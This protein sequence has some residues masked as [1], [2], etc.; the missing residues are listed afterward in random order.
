MAT[1]LVLGTCDT[2]LDETLF[3]K[4]RIL[5]QAS[6]RK[7]GNNG[8]S[9]VLVMDV[10]R[11]AT[12]DDRIEIKQQEVVSR[13]TA[14]ISNGNGNDDDIT[15]LPRAE[16][17]RR[18]TTGAIV[19]AREEF[20]ASRIHGIVGLGGTCGTT[21]AT[22]VM[23]EALP[24]GFPKLMV[25]T[26]GSADVKPYVGETDITMMYSV[27][28]IAGINSIL[29]MALSNAA[30]AVAGMAL[31]YY[32]RQASSSED[33]SVVPSPKTKRV[34]ITM[35][36]VTTPCVDRIRHYLTSN[37][38]FEVYAFHATGS[39]GR[40][41]ERLIAERQLDAVLDLTTTEVADH[42]VGGVMDPGPHRLEMGAKSG[43]PQIVSVGACDMV[44]FGPP[45]TLPE[46]FRN[47]VGNTRLFHEHN[48]SITLMR[49]TPDES[50]AMGRFM[51]QRLRGAARPENV[52]VLLPVGGVSMLD[53]R[54][55]VFCDPMADAALFETLEDGLRG[56]GVKVIRDSRDINDPGF[57]ASTAE[58]FVDMIRRSDE[59]VKHVH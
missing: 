15:K 9:R 3:V 6:G 59:E 36:G 41:M 40:A 26:M 19:I 1:V 7:D 22:T 13:C 11:T 50:R 45:G 32:G 27:V 12:Q 44:N 33:G 54:G 30:G 21:L 49:T 20:R 43:I 17:I 2:K 38:G 31:A 52:V 35:F 53:V 56:T 57:A 4:D 34:G 10:G 58:M 14:A 8:I 37:H 48:P 23:R 55:Q 24:V 25:S 47:R 39:G 16:Y 28:D 46:K 5:A 29:S 51:V 18:I 42:I